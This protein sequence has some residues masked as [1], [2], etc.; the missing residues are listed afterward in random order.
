MYTSPKDEAD[1]IPMRHSMAIT[2]IE[3]ASLAG[4]VA[5][6]MRSLYTFYSTFTAADRAGSIK[7][8]L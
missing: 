2:V 5:R 6:C 4:L 3:D 7:C 8:S 1:G